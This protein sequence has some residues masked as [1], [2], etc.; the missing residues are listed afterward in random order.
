MHTSALLIVPGWLGAHTWR[1]PILT[2]K[3]CNGM[4]SIRFSFFIHFLCVWG[5]FHRLFNS[6]WLTP[7]ISFHS[8]CAW[9]CVSR[10]FSALKW[11]K[12]H[13]ILPLLSF[14]YFFLY[15]RQFPR[16]PKLKYYIICHK[17]LL[18]L[19]HFP[20]ESYKINRLVSFISF[21]QQI[22]CCY[23]ITVVQLYNSPT[24][25]E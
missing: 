13:I 11:M 18:F 25:N 4:Y 16:N 10:H 22:K 9:K 20:T 7:T 24:Q 8:K 14:L 12:M 6:K 21:L 2:I 5:R 17:S 1:L 3:I 19:P 23:S 15:L